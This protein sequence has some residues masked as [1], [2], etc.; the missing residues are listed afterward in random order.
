MCIRDRI[1][2]GLKNAIEHGESLQNAMQIMINAGYNPAEVQEASKF[3]GGGTLHLQK[4]KSD[5]HLTMPEQKSRLSKLA[6]WKKRQKSKFPQTQKPAQKIPPQT[7]QPAQPIQQTPQQPQTQPP[8]QQL[9]QTQPKKSEPL[10]KQL[11]EIKPKVKSHLKEIILLI[12]LLILIGVLV[13][14]IF[15][16]DK[17]IGWFS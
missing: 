13:A 6:F 10:T 14:T 9:M 1:I 4:P 11:K 16:K 7:Q 3:V 8:S 2:T 12:I 17:I 5:E 15:L